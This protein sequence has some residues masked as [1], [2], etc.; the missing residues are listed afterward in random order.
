VKAREDREADLQARI[1]ELEAEICELRGDKKLELEAGGTLVFEDGALSLRYA[2]DSSWYIEATDIPA[3]Q[4]FLAE[5][6]DELD[7]DE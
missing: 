4:D 2:N 5:I 3:I 1:E 7:S 6:Q